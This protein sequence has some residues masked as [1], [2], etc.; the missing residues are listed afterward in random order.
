MVASTN[1]PLDEREYPDQSDLTEDDVL[2]SIID[3]PACGA[4]IHEDTPKCP[5]C[6]EWVSHSLGDWRRS[7]KWYV[8]GGRLAAKALLVNWPVAVG[9]SIPA[10]LFLLARGC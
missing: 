3:C 4:A 6:G 9:L 8:R 7:R 5:N 2:G 10:L 1:K